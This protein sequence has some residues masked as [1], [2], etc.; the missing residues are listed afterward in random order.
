MPTRA[1]GLGPRAASQRMQIWVSVSQCLRVCGRG[2]PRQRFAASSQQ[3]SC[4]R[5]QAM[6]PRSAARCEVIHTYNATP[7]SMAT[8]LSKTQLQQPAAAPILYPSPAPQ[9]ARANRHPLRLPP[10]AHP[11][12]EGFRGG[13]TSSPRRVRARADLAPPAAPIYITRPCQQETRARDVGTLRR[14]MLPERL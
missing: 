2:S 7:R 10:P 9:R 5:T 11:A 14:S 8:A 4:R 13:G 6:R 3:G 1:T 12:A